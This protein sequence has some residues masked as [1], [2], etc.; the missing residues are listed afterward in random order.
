MSHDSLLNGLS[1]WGCLWQSTM[2]I[3]LG[4]VASR[5]LRRRPS[6]AYQV[7]LCT[8]MAA[9]VVPFMST[10]VKHFDLGVFTAR[11]AEP[12]RTSQEV[13]PVVP[14]AENRDMKD[15]SATTEPVMALP[16]GVDL[17]PARTPPA[18]HRISWRAVAMVTWLSATCVLLARLVVT[19][20]Y[21]ATIVRQAQTLGCAQVQQAV[22]A[23]TSELGI[24]CTLQVRTSPSIRSPVVWCWGRAPIMLVPNVCEDPKVDWAGVAA[25]ELAHCKRQD[26]V[27]GLTAELMLCLLPWHPM[28]WWSKKRLIRL[29][30][31]ACDDWVVATGQPSEDYAESL[32]R[33]SPQGQ[34]AFLSAVVHSKKGLAFRINRIL[35]NGC[36][37]P[38]TGALW[39]LV[40]G[41]AVVC[42]SVGIALAQTRPEK[43]QHETQVQANPAEP[44]QEATEN[45]GM[46]QVKRL[47]A[48][49]ADRHV[50]W[51]HIK[52]TST[53]LDDQGKKIPERASSETETWHG[54]E[55]R[56]VIWKYSGGSMTLRD[57]AR[58]EVH[59][60]NPDSKRII[61]TTLSAKGFLPTESPWTWMEGEIQR[62]TSRGGNVQHNGGQYHGKNVHVFEM[63]D[64]DK[65]DRAIR[66]SKLYVDRATS[67]PMAEDT[68]YINPQTGN[69]Q[70]IGTG[71][72]SYPEEGPVD[73]YDLGLS[74]DIPTIDSRPFPTWREIKTIYGTHRQ[75]IPAEKYIAIVTRELAIG[76]SPVE[77]AEI[78]YADGA[79]LRLERHHLLGR[80]SV[81]PQWQEQKDEFGGTFDAILKWS[82]GFKAHGPIS[83]QISDQ[84]QVNYSSRGTDGIWKAVVEKAFERPRTSR[85]TWGMC[86]IARLAWPN[87]RDM[88]DIIQDDY[89]RENDLIRV[90]AK[91]NIYYLNP[92]RDYICERQINAYGQISD[93]TVYHQTDGGHWY[94]RRIDG[95]TS[96][97]TIWLE[98]NPEPSD[99]LFDLSGLVKRVQ[100]PEA[101]PITIDTDSEFN[102][103]PD[104]L[105]SVF[106]EFDIEPLLTINETGDIIFHGSI[107][108][109]ESVTIRTILLPEGRKVVD[110]RVTGGR[111]A[112]KDLRTDIYGSI[113]GRIQASKDN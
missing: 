102:K 44:L 32:L 27:T 36:G 11:S 107:S 82:A 52:Y 22:E 60:Y 41:G 73:L 95:F 4:L 103:L 1:L 10:V 92:N 71:E 105:T 87:I 6:R 72:M 5:C 19:F 54:F 34:M 106:E 61:L 2:F 7:L 37:N 28:I 89:A 77:S 62:V 40:M 46:E 97:H 88:G 74:R 38:R 99:E 69:P 96:G 56:I 113:A 65:P 12:L 50:P 31:Q 76:G 64:A 35:H 100:P 15:L 48:K 80:G 26:H 111:A 14:P 55:S 23:V 70:L 49:G 45:Q 58:Q 8:M 47:M 78:C 16:T 108:P 90:E 20:L 104:I 94:P 79:N 3:V 42:L 33:F 86:E 81:S 59:T 17:E 85:D 110:I 112:L 98:T 68:E 9:V 67:L 43:S 75:R 109:S 57:Y 93:V 53:L 18:R 63:S 84:K 66:H 51:M 25:H 101:Y 39:A 24:P 29:G 13:P 30:E 91:D 21:G 83:I